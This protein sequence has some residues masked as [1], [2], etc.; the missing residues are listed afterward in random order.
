M[1]DS[2][3]L[4]GWEWYGN[5]AHF[6][7]AK[8]C[9]FHL[10]T[11]VGQYVVS[12]VGDYYPQGSERKIEPTDIGSNRTHETMVFAVVGRCKCGCNLPTHD[13]NEVDFCGY[14]CGADAAKGHIALCEKWA[15]K[16]GKEVAG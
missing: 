8:D 9:R 15:G 3:D 4:A 13:G 10:T 1:S 14:N 16:V 6:C 2:I 12:T 11:E 7:G 5:A